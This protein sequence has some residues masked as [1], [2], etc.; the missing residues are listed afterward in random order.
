MKTQ[1]GYQTWDSFLNQFG[2]NDLIKE[3]FLDI[4]LEEIYG[5]TREDLPLS[6]EKR[7]VSNPNTVNDGI[8]EMPTYEIE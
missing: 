4:L 2:E 7:Q 1:K 6:S 8:R 3:A 5:Q